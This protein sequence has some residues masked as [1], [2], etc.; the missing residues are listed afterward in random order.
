MIASALDAIVGLGLT[1]RDV[2]LHGAPMFHLVDAWSIWSMP[3]IGAPQVALH[4][5]PEGLMQVVQRT[6]ATGAGLPPTLINLM[7]NHP[8]IGT[9]DLVEPALHHV[10]R[11]ADATR[12]T[13]EG[14]Q[15]H[16]DHVHPRLRHYRDIGHHHARPS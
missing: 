15:D 13:A 8:K 14:G 4:F 2:W 5:T 1:D 11:L 7:A 9:Y 16:S 3:L 10:R 6:K 12:H